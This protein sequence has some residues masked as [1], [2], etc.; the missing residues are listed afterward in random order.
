MWANFNVL[1][2][3]SFSVKHWFAINCKIQIKQNTLSIQKL[4][5]ASLWLYNKKLY[6]YHKKTQPNRIK[7]YQHFSTLHFSSVR[8]LSSQRVY[9]FIACIFTPLFTHPNVVHSPYIRTPNTSVGSS[10]QICISP[11][12]SLAVW[13]KC[14]FQELL[15]MFANRF[16]ARRQSSSPYSRDRLVVRTLRC[17]RSNPGS[18]PGHGNVSHIP[19][20]LTH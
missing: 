11:L 1:S 2:V 19:L 18:N 4:F 3:Y 12:S 10:Q 5:L 17:G 7:Q 13:S 16:L 15:L 6:R 20:T 9:P 8:V 14:S